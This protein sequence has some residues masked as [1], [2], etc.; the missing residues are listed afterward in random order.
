VFD[1]DT[2]FSRRAATAATARAFFHADSPDKISQ[3][4]VVKMIYG[5]RTVSLDSKTHHVFSIGT[6]KNDPV[7]ITAKNSNRRPKP[8]L[9]TF[10]LIELEK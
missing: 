8:D 9:S 6:E 10:E 7:P 5:A 1:P 3:V 2:T 4:D